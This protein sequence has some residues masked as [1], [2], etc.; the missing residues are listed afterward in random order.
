MG[1]HHGKGYVLNFI[2]F[3]KLVIV[4]CACP[5]ILNLYPYHCETILIPQCPLHQVRERCKKEWTM[6]QDR[7]ANAETAYFQAMG[8]DLPNST[9]T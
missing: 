9:A 1:G 5:L 4:S 2:P 3:N 8:I 6:F 7:M